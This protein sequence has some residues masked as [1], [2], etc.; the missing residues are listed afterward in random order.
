MA[1]VNYLNSVFAYILMAGVPI[2]QV[3]IASVLHVQQWSSVGAEIWPAYL[4]P[5]E[6]RQ[7]GL[8]AL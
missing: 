7:V 5:L 1:Q 8:P 6:T 2:A 3:L 4:G